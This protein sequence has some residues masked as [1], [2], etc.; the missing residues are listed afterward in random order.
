MSQDITTFA[1]I[2]QEIRDMIFLNIASAAEPCLDNSDNYNL[3]LHRHWGGKGYTQCIALLHQWAPR[4]YFA[5]AACEMFWSH[6]TFRHGWYSE[7]EA[8][9]DP[10]KPLHI[11]ISDDEK[12]PV[13]TFTDLREC[14]QKLELYTNP[15]PVSFAEPTHDDTQSLL[16]LKRQL[17]QLHEF[18]RLRHVELKIWI[19]TESDAYVEGMTVVESIVDA[20]K[21]LRARIGEGLK[22]VLH[23]AWPYDVN[24]FP[25]LEETDISW[26]W[27]PPSREDR[28]CVDDVV[29]SWEQWIRLLVADGVGPEAEY[30]LLEELRYAGERLP[31]E[32]EEIAVM[33]YWE[34]WLGVSEEKFGEIKREREERLR[35]EEEE[36]RVVPFQW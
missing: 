10:Q 25:L 9:I 29:E 12:K 21:E 17:A 20:C 24:K 19:D 4:L 36:V 5:K 15:N 34:P 28:K 3:L 31:Q 2:P 11:G 33:E 8:I 26:M 16:K 18:P 14:V 30:T 13:R 35:R 23:R 22:V 32:K 1:D 7:A 27:E 6:A